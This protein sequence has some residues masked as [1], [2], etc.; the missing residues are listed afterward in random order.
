MENNT[1]PF[2]VHLLLAGRRV[3]VAGGG[4]VAHR[5]VQ[6]LLAAGAWIRVVAPEIMPEIEVSLQ[7]GEHQCL[8]RKVAKQDLQDC[9]LVYAATDSETIN[10]DVAVWSHD[11]HCICCLVD[12]QWPQGDFITPAKIQLDPWTISL[13]DQHRRPA[14]LKAMKEKLLSW[15]LKRE[16]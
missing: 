2:P 10:A 9:L 6:G 14:E 16:R 4:K 8:K 15:M 3:L 12:H 5:K 11:Y 1:P 13:S 7:A